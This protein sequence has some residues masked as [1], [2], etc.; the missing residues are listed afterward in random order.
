MEYL[1]FESLHCTPELH[2]SITPQLKKKGKKEAKAARQSCWLIWSLLKTL[3]NS[4]YLTIYRLWLYI[5]ESQFWLQ[6]K[7]NNVILST[8][9][10]N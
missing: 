7:K 8:N 6:E 3:D 9:L 1:Y 5:K 2:K 4:A 10:N